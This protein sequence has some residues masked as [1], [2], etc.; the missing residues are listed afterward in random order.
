MPLLDLD[1]ITTGLS[2]T[3]TA[4]LGDWDRSLRA[5]NYP[6]TTRY[7]YVLA[8]GQLARYLGEYLPDPEAA[9]AAEDPVE[10]SRAHVESF[11][12]WMIQTRSAATALNKHKGLQQFFRWLRDDEQEIERSPM[13]RVRQPKTPQKLIPIIRDE[14]TAKVLATCVGKSFAA[15][16]DEAIIRLLYN[17]GARLSEVAGLHLGD[18]DLTTDSVCYHGKGSK[19]RRVRFGPK[20]GRALSRYLRAR[21]KHQGAGLHNTTVEVVK[22]SVLNQ[23]VDAVVNA[24]NTA[25]QGGGGIDG[26]IHN[27]AGPQLLA[28]LKRA[29]PQ[30]AKTG[31]AVLTKG[32]K[33][34]QPFIIHTPGPVWH[35]GGRGEPDL[36]A[37]CYRACLRLADEHRLKSIAFC[38]LST[39]IFGYPLDKAA[40]LA[41]QT[42][43]EYI[44]AHPNTALEHVVF[45]MFQDAEFRAYTAALTAQSGGGAG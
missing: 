2:R 27:A 26:V 14:D 5:G 35:G 23:D 34:K 39:G 45:S 13:E 36:L 44:D 15:L 18:V 25:M 7:I 12:A 22:G 11:Q 38:S 19:D 6:E 4:L 31:T 29:A 42:V 43:I 17:T 40:P 32:H 30:G 1:K 20:T 41:V 16:R 24:A 10:V 37:S 9:A 3:W 28:E 21:A 8:A 33:L